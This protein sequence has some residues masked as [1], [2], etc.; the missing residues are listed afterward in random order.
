VSLDVTAAQTILLPAG[1]FSYQL[2]AVLADGDRVTIAQGK[3]TVWAA[4]GTPPLFPESV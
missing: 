3:L 4:P 1:E 2:S